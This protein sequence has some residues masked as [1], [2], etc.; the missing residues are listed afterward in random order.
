VILEEADR[1]SAKVGMGGHDPECSVSSRLA[2]CD[3]DRLLVARVLPE[4]LSQ[5]RH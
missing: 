1:F 4:V 2:F 3:P 5:T